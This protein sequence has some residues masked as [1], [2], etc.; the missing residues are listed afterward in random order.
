[1]DAKTA[2]RFRAATAMIVEVPPEIAGACAK[3]LTS[4]GYRVVTVGHVP[5]ACERMAVVMPLLV[6]G[7]AACPQHARDELRERAVAVGADLLWIDAGAEPAFTASTVRIAAAA[8]LQKHEP[9]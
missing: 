5:A 9:G 2:Q 8:A 4:H 3:I 1:M 7:D 6:I